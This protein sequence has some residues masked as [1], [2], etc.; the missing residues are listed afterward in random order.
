MAENR[1]HPWNLR[2]RKASHSA[3]HS[4]FLCWI[5]PGGGRNFS[6]MGWVTL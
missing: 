6:F 3:S 1:S 4:G 2:Q 5:N